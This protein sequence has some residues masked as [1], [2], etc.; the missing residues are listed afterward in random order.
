MSDI[1]TVT[2]ADFEDVV[3]KSELPV[4]VDFYGTWCGPCKKLKPV[5]EE[6]AGEFKE[7]VKVVELE[8]TEAP[9]TAASFGVMGVP[10]LILFKDGSPAETLVGGAGKDALTKLLSESIN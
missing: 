7:R 3:L 4:L 1:I 6:L 5:I 10:T 2:D 9:N 8:V